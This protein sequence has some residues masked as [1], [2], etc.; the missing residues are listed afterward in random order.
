MGAHRAGTSALV[1]ALQSL[2]FF[3][4]AVKDIHNEAVFFQSLNIW[5]MENSGAR[6]DVPAPIEFFW[7]DPELVDSSERYVRELLAGRA[8]EDFWGRPRRFRGGTPSATRV[9]GWKD[10]RN[11]FTTPFWLRVFPKARVVSIRRH[12]VD[13]AASLRTRARRSLETNIRRFQELRT[14]RLTRPRRRHLAH[15]ARCLTLA[16]AF[17]LWRE[18]MEQGDSVARSLPPERRIEIVFEELVSAPERVLPRLCTFC[19]LPYSETTVAEQ[20]RAL[21]RARAYAFES[22]EELSAFAFQ[23]RSDLRRFGY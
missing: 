4:G 23:K 19:G 14:T 10:P 5:I 7:H 18:Y 11:T 13:V 8:A 16:G 3:A 9:W 20:G 22:D 6:W 2:G 12:G 15:S 1:E 17:D 21:N